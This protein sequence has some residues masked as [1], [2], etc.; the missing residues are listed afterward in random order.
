MN[1]TKEK[2]LN[3]T[4]KSQPYQFKIICG[5]HRS[6]TTYT[7]NILSKNSSLTTI[8][9]P[10]NPDWGVSEQ[11][12]WYPFMDAEAVDEETAAL[13]DDILNFRC[14][15]SNRPPRRL[16]LKSHVMYRAV[17]GKQGLVWSQLRLKHLIH[18]LP[19]AVVWK[20]PF[21][22]FA[23]GHLLT[24]YNAKAVCLIRHPGALWYSN[25]KLNWPFEIERLRTQSALIEK[26]GQDIPDKYWQMATP[27]SPVCIAILWKLMARVIAEQAARYE[28]LLAVRHED[29]CLQALETAQKI[30]QHLDLTCEPE[31]IAYITKTTSGKRSESKQGVA[32]SFNR[33]SKQI[34]DTWRGRLDT[35]EET[36]IREV[37]GDDLFKFY[38]TW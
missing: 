9:E 15:W 38:E 33:D 22:T 6:G 31:M 1:Q 23:L 16:P 18:Q 34:I 2:D 25:R 30:C 26:Y 11:I 29:L 13:F 12:K 21:V 7:G 36:L 14:R 4:L 17:G 27:D 8:H 24:T 3:K 20:D 10:C 32:H 35:T 19:P 37:I 5:L 28:S